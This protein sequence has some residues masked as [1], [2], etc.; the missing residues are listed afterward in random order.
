[1]MS[2]PDLAHAEPL[3]AALRRSGALDGGKVIQV[4]VESSQPTILS[5]IF[6][7]RPTYEGQAQGAP[8]SLIL[9]AGLVDRPG[10]PWKG[11]RNEVAFYRDVA[12]AMPAGLVPHCFDAAWEAKTGAW[13]LLLED[14]TDS[15][16]IA[17]RWPLPPTWA[18]CE[19]I[20]R[21]RA[22][23]QAAWWDDPRLGSTIGTWRDAAAAKAG[24][25]RFAEQF[26][27]FADDLGDR[28]SRERRRLYERLIEAAPRLGARYDGRRHMTLVQGDAHVWNCFLPKTPGTDDARLFDWD[29]WHIGVAAEDLAYLMAVHWYPDLRSRIERPL[30]DCYHETLLRQGVASYDRGAL[31]DD[32]RLAALWQM[33]TPILQH[34]NAIPPVI[35]WNN[36]E[37]I[38][39]AIDDLGCRDLLD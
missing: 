32:Y 10:G 16:V 30:L 20:I 3:T 38:H 39:L 15:H 26:T 11:G 35:W 21:T 25:D 27:G 31:A 1:M 29:S 18:Q 13:H 2:L 6:R 7:L 37:R 28:L 36:F 22:R 14:L 34:A 19:S 17:T 5:H 23:F 4:A 12:A 8:A 9:K 33:A 24:L